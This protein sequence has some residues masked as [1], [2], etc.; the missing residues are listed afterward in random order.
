MSVI[1][2]GLNISGEEAQLSLNRLRTYE[3]F[4]NMY[5]HYKLFGLHYSSKW[6][7]VFC[8]LKGST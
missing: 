3:T 8:I 1:F 6:I 4:G 2:E 7:S 5:M